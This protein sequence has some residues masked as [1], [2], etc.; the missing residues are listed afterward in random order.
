M[1]TIPTDFECPITQM[2]MTDPVFDANGHTFERVA[3]TQWYNTSNISPITHTPVSHK[4]LTSNVLL[5]RQ[6]LEYQEGNRTMIH[7]N[8]ESS[9]VNIDSPP[10]NILV[11]HQLVNEKTCVELDTSQN[12]SNTNQH[13]ILLVDRSG[14][15]SNKVTVKD[16]N[17]TEVDY[18]ITLLDVV[19]QSI[20]TLIKILLDDDVKT[21]HLTIITFNS[22]AEKECNYMLVNKSN[23]IYLINLI[24]RICAC[25]TTNIWDAFRLGFETIKSID[26]PDYHKMILFTDGIPNNHPFPSASYSAQYTTEKYINC[27][28]AYTKQQDIVCQINTIGFGRGGN[29]DSELLLEIAKNQ[30]GIF[31]F[32][33]DVSMLA[34]TWLYIIANII[35]QTDI[36]KPVLQYEKDGI[37]CTKKVNRLTNNQTKLVFLPPDIRNIKFTYLKCDNTPE[38]VISESK[39][40]ISNI[41]PEFCRDKLCET[42]GFV[43]NYMDIGELASAKSLLDTF[44]QLVNDNQSIFSGWIGSSMDPTLQ[45]YLD[46]ILTSGKQ[47]EGGQITMAISDAKYYQDWG[48]HFIRALYNAHLNKC[49]SNFK[50]KG[51]NYTTPEIQAHLSKMETIYLSLPPPKPSAKT[52]QTKVI[53]SNQVL[54][55]PRGGCYSGDSQIE[56]DNG[57]KSVKT[58]KKGDMVKTPNGYSRILCVVFIKQHSDGCKMCDLGNNNFITP[59]HPVFYQN[60]WCFPIHHFD[61]THLNIDYVYNFV[62]ESEHQIYINNYL[63]PTFGHNIKGDVIS[64]PFFGSH[65]II[66]QLQQ[67]NGFINGIIN[68]NYNDF[69][70]D[71]ETNLISNIKLA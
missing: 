12:Q 33:S 70:R 42:L 54:Y 26:T 50:D 69:I 15:M 64:H 58:L 67:C 39:T 20:K 22:I 60:K 13:L 62:L 61:Q 31:A 3:I 10:P 71:S 27:L 17:N 23:E 52:H 36:Q 16:S 38:V 56:T 34:S 45:G 2:I 48:C 59:Y 43:I 51:L 24:D 44:C 41:F 66:Q 46:D 4:T 68:I 49:K 28:D 25:S 1:S 11:N 9:P 18:G 63:T 53:Q 8:I 35:H 21:Y 19:K 47:H 6:I 32:M 37:T 40:D 65:K 14:S 55:Q 30:E 57:P 7:T 29:L 5:K